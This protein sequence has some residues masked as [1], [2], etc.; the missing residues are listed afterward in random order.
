MWNSL[1]PYIATVVPSLGVGLIFYFV[2]RALLNAD[3]LEREAE[4]EAD[5]KALE[6]HQPLQNPNTQD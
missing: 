4:A 6:N 5:R 1:Y 3:K 2:M